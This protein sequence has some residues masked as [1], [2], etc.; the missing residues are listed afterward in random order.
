MQTTPLY[1]KA[2][3]QRCFSIAH[4]TPATA[5]ITISLDSTTIQVDPTP[6]DFLEA[7]SVLRRQT[8]SNH[9]KPCS[10]HSRPRQATPNHSTPFQTTPNLYGLKWSENSNNCERSRKTTHVCASSKYR[11]ETFAMSCQ[12]FPDGSMQLRITSDHFGKGFRPLETTSNQLP[13]HVKQL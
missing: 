8:T 1:S 12:T 11:S 3:G 13:K 2:S 9:I 4:T 10:D 5:P 6:P 7:A